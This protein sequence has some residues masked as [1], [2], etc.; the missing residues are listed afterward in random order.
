MLQH[1]LHMFHA[2]VAS[3]VRSRSSGRSIIVVYMYG[4]ITIIGSYIK[5]LVS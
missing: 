1:V 4:S 5:V 2:Y 3:V